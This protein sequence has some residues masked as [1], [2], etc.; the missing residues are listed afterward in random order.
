M[1]NEHS[2]TNFYQFINGFRVS[3]FKM[4]MQSP[5]AQQLSILGLAEEAGFSSK[6][7]FYTAFKAV[8]GVTPKQYELSLKKSE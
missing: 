2:K 6:S 8:E 1:I 7:T 5:K 3:E 4:L